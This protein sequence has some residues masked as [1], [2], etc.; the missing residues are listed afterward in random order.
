MSCYTVLKKRALHEIYDEVS[1][2]SFDEMEV[3]NHLRRN[4]DDYYEV[5]EAIDELIQ[6]EYFKDINDFIQFYGSD[7]ILNLFS[8]DGIKKNFEQIFIRKKFM[9][10]NLELNIVPLMNR[11]QMDLKKNQLEIA[12]I[13]AL[14]KKKCTQNLQR[15][16]INRLRTS[17]YLNLMRQ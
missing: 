16:L 9:P 4:E 17:N 7:S 10:K 14:F 12:L 5:F 8:D 6:S 13:N 1:Q 2:I 11:M 15:T 3:Y